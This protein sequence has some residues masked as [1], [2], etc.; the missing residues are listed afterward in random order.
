MCFSVGDW[1]RL[2]KAWLFGV[3]RVWFFRGAV[4]PA[5]L[6]SGEEDQPE[7]GRPWWVPAVRFSMQAPR[8]LISQGRILAQGFTIPL[9][10]P[11]EVL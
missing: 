6:L 5:L 7:L 3:G 2:E 11:K 9:P 8:L 1:K 10:T 4:F